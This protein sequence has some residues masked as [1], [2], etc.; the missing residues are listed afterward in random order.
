MFVLYSPHFPQTLSQ[1]TVFSGTKK[2][3]NPCYSSPSHGEVIF[4]SLSLSFHKMH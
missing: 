1:N 4:L 3:I 2:G